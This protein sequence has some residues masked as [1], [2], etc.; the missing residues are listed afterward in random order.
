MASRNERV[1]KIGTDKTQL[2]RSLKFSLC[3]PF[4]MRLFC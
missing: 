4:S 2:R 1:G 3:S